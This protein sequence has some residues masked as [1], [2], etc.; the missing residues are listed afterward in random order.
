MARMQPTA[1]TGPTTDVEVEDAVAVEGEDKR[2]VLVSTHEQIGQLFKG[3]VC[4]IG[5]KP[6]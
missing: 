2:E 3:S 6:D 5:V 4:H 1:T